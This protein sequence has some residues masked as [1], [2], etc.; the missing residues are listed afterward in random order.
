MNQR[1]QDAMAI[2][3]HYHGFNLFITFTSNPRWEALTSELLPGQTTADR[4]DLVVR[5]FN[6]YKDALLHDIANNNIF[7]HTHARV[8]SIEFQKRGLPHMH[9]LLSLFPCDRPSMPAEVDSVIC[10]SWPDP[11]QEPILFDIVK[12]CMVHGPC[13]RA[14]PHALCMKDGKC[15]KGFPKPYQ[16]HT[17]MT[18]EGY[19]TYTRPPDGHSYE[20]GGFAVDNRWIMPY[21]PYL[22]L[23]YI[24]SFVNV[25]RLIFHM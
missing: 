18:T 15:S 14:F 8:H 20:V 6:M 23:R 2:A 3:R 10:A 4:P 24:L 21:N 16:L 13:G 22:L 17:L 12:R 25:H 19:P 1:Y 9:L 7:G 5:V 11:H